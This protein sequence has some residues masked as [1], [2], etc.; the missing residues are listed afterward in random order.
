MHVAVDES[1]LGIVC[2]A[3]DSPGHPTTFPTLATP[4]GTPFQAAPP[5]HTGPLSG[6]IT[7]FVFPAPDGPKDIGFCAVAIYGG[8][9]AVSMAVTGA[10]ATLRERRTADE[11]FQKLA[12]AYPHLP[13]MWL[14]QAAE[15]LSDKSTA[16]E[17]L[18]RCVMHQSPHIPCFC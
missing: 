13:T 14:Q 9:A 18:V 16:K 7:G 2:C 10:A 4:S 15:F 12:A 5:G 17:L 8:G 6:C 11:A 1:A 3:V